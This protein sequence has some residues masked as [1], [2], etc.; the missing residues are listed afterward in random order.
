MATQESDLP[1]FTQERRVVA[2]NHEQNIICSKRHLDDTT[3]EQTIICRLLFA[4]HVEGPQLI[5]LKE[6]VIE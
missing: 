6:N 3:H 2:V 4:A 1:F 5:K